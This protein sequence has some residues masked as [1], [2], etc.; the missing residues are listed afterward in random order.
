VCEAHTKTGVGKFR[1]AHGKR[2]SHKP[3]GKVSNRPVDLRVPC[4]L[5]W[6]GGKQRAPGDPNNDPGAARKKRP[7]AKTTTDPIPNMGTGLSKHR[8]KARGESGGFGAFSE[9]AAASTDVFL[10]AGNKTQNRGQARRNVWTSLPLRKNSKGGY[11]PRPGRPPN[12][13]PAQV[14]CP[15]N[16]KVRN[17]RKSGRCWGWVLQSEKKKRAGGKTNKRRTG[18]DLGSRPIFWTNLTGRKQTPKRK[19]SVKLARGWSP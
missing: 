12:N 5:G 18:G 8:E 17:P 6:P 2:I 1:N 7:E 19:S 11:L 10:G 13:F 15:D 4:R 14:N 9:H 16:L 3:Y